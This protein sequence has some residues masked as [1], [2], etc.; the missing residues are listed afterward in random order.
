[1]SYLVLVS[2]PVGSGSNGLTAELANAGAVEVHGVVQSAAHQLIGLVV[3]SMLWY[4]IIDKAF[5]LLGFNWL[6]RHFTR[7]GWNDNDGDQ[8]RWLGQIG[9]LGGL[10]H[11][12]VP[13]PLDDI[14]LFSRISE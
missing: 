2:V 8:V 11:Q 5:A 12:R 4:F 13:S 14:A 10:R 1:M 3:V 6:Q 7:G 9:G